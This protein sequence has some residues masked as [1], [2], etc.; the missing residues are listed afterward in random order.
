M[1]L[2][3]VGEAKSTVAEKSSGGKSDRNTQT[4]DVAGVPEN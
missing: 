2:I 3:L 1:H 4:G